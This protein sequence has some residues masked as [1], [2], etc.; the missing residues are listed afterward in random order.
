MRTLTSTSS[1]LSDIL[2]MNHSLSRLK[3]SECSRNTSFGLPLPDQWV[4]DTIPDNVLIQQHIFAC[5][6]HLASCIF[7]KGIEILK[8]NTGSLVPFSEPRNNTMW[9]AHCF[10]YAQ[11]HGR[12]HSTLKIVHF[13]LASDF[14]KLREDFFLLLQ[15]WRGW[16]AKKSHLLQL[17]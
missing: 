7:P 5:F 17:E 1:G 16:E 15:L 12:T 6:P 10:S 4:Y 3:C 11:N 14:L 13:L 9:G 8:V 2:C